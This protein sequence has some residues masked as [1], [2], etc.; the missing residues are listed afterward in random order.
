MKT[1]TN[2]QSWLDTV[3]PDYFQRAD[4][5]ESVREKKQAGDFKTEQTDNGQNLVTCPFCDEALCL[6]SETARQTFIRIVTDREVPDPDDLDEGYRRA[7][8]D[9]HS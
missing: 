3:D 4:L 1:T 7:V 6:A 5:L 9:P 8:N 2:F